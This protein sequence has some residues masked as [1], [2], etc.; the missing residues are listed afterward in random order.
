MSTNDLSDD[1]FNINADEVY[2]IV[3][4]RHEIA[5]R[6]LNFI[7]KEIKEFLG[8]FKFTHD[9]L[10]TQTA[11]DEYNSTSHTNC[12]NVE[13]E[14]LDEIEDN[15]DQIFSLEKAME[16]YT[17]STAL[18]ELGNQ[19]L[20]VEYLA[21]CC[22]PD[23]V[24]V[25]A[26]E[27]KKVNQG[28][29]FFSLLSEVYIRNFISELLLAKDASAIDSDQDIAASI[30]RFFAH[31]IL[32]DI[33]E[34][35]ICSFDFEVRKSYIIGI[36]PSL[37]ILTRQNEYTKIFKSIHPNRQ[38]STKATHKKTGKEKKNTTHL[39]RKLWR[40]GMKVVFCSITK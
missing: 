34:E 4:E 37:L 8:N 36:L 2:R 10:P 23:N 29:S 6:S 32:L 19:N 17:R 3:N 16:I 20:L 14:S 21:K 39:S 11:T 9:N 5:L 27:L 25:A 33:G 18:I 28:F 24:S 1:I 38:E 40:L 31:G 7:P 22:A 30:L 13:F 26:K 35:G 12:T 15:L